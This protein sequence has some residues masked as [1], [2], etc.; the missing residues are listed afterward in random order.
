MFG[1]LRDGTNLT[2]TQPGQDSF[3]LEPVSSPMLSE[4]L[5]GGH[6]RS[7]CQRLES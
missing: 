7:W 4:S 1:G 2:A 6:I 5:I 3:L